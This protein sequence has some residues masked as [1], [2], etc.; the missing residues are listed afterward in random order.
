V[1]DKLDYIRDLGATAIWMNPIFRNRAIQEYGPAKPAKAR[2]IT[3]IG[4]WILLTSIR[5][6][7]QRPIMDA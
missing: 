1:T 4:F 7:V 5:T 3:V 2:D 6:L